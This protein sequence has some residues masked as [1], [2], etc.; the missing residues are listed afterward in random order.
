MRNNLVSLR[1]KTKGKNL[2]SLLIE[3]KPTEGSYCFI[4]TEDFLRKYLKEVLLYNVY[5]IPEDNITLITREA[6]SESWQHVTGLTMIKIGEITDSV[7]NICSST[8]IDARYRVH[9]CKE[10]YLTVDPVLPPL[11]ANP[12]FG[13]REPKL[14]E[15][16]V[17]VSK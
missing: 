16:A 10:G 5:F 14:W 2:M 6:F 9:K 8:G 15:D 3:H 13:Y 4:P 12:V 11:R 1:F 7:F 17:A